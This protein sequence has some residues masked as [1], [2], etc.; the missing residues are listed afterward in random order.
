[1]AYVSFALGLQSGCLRF[2]FVV[3]LPGG[4]VA[5]FGVVCKPDPTPAL[6]RG[7]RWRALRTVG[8]LY[9]INHLRF[10]SSCPAPVPLPGATLAE[11]TRP[12]FLLSKKP[13]LQL[14]KPADI[15]S[16]HTLIST[17]TPEGSSSFISA[18]IVL[19]VDE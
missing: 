5:A 13:G 18:S 15:L 19:G 3:V 4:V 10:P 14:G 12:R 1:M 16:D 8:T 11:P 9:I 6:P 7:G 2:F 17:S